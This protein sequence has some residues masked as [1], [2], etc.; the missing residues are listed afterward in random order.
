MGQS[1]SD[2]MGKSSPSPQAR[3]KALARPRLSKR[4]GRS[5]DYLKSNDSKSLD[6]SRAT[7][8]KNSGPNDGIEDPPPGVRA[9]RPFVGDDP[10]EC[11]E[12]VSRSRCG[13]EI[14]QPRALDPRGAGSSPQAVG[15]TLFQGG[16]MRVI[17]LE[18]ALFGITHERF[19]PLLRTVGGLVPGM[20]S[21]QSVNAWVGH[22][23]AVEVVVRMLRER[24]LTLDSSGTPQP[25]K[26]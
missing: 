16:L 8:E 4:L 11:G 13:V 23:D 15:Q 3:S 25:P 21:V 2:P 24:G 26:R 14:V 5:G 12:H 1:S 19:S 10:L 9:K 22:G 6:A 20:R 18:G 17:A 7:P